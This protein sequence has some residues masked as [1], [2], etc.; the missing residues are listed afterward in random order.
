MKVALIYT[1]R[2]SADPTA[3]TRENQF[4]I[5]IKLYF[6]YSFN[7]GR[8]QSFTDSNVTEIYQDYQEGLVVDLEVASIQEEEASTPG[9]PTKVATGPRVPPQDLCLPS[10]KASKMG[11]RASTWEMGEFYCL[12]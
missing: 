12:I 7:N 5:D 10:M 4:K 9:D 8:N 11:S 3:D 2:R 1:S 6:P